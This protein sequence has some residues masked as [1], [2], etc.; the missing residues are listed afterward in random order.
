MKNIYLEG[1]P[2]FCAKFLN[3]TNEVLAAG[4]KKH[5][6]SYNLVNDKLEKI[7]SFLFTNRFEKKINYFEVSKNE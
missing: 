4:M 5:L 1:L 2:L 3:S 6:L 7:S